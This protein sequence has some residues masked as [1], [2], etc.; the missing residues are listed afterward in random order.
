MRPDYLNIRHLPYDVLN[1]IKQILIDKINERPGYLLEDSYQN[2][3]AYIQQP[4]EQNLPESFEQLSILDKR[5]DL[6]SEE[7]FIDLYKLK[8]N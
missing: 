2:L 5:R 1:Y 8:G 6:N 4:I 3:L 7:I